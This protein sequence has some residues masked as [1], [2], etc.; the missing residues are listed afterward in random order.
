MK[1]GKYNNLKVARIVDF[2]AYLADEQD[3]T[4]VLLPAR[5]IESA[6]EI[7]EEM[8]VF[9]YRDSDDRPV[10]VTDR[11]F[12]IV[13]EFAFL[14]VAAV[15]KV[16]A[17][18]DWELPKELLV[19]FREQR[20]R[21]RVGG[22]Y[23]V[24]VYLD[25]ATGRIVA[26]AKLE[27]FLDNLMPEYH[28][29]QM[30]DALVLRETSV[31]YA[32]IVDNLYSGMIY[33]NELFESPT[34]GDRVKAGVKRVRPDGKIDLTYGGNARRRSGSTARNIM[35]FLAENQSLPVGDK[36]SPE[37]IA[38]LFKCSK[39]DFKKALGLLLREK[40]VAFDEL[41]VIVSLSK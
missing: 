9:V 28:P 20:A 24:Y 6:L 35:D 8:E 11:P 4:E 10:A 19:P 14:R 36:S 12:A 40:K 1:I 38:A 33:H 3:G 27:K 23:P 31:G 25:D 37:E 21:M 18:L 15:N 30:V 5:Y 17:F 13:G 16:G 26:S 7:G 34:R 22:V 39:K 41:G 32:C 29:G 2:G